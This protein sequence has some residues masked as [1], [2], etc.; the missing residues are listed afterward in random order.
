MHIRRDVRIRLSGAPKYYMNKIYSAA[1]NCY[2]HDLLDNGV[3]NNPRYYHIFVGVNTRYLETYPLNSKSNTDVQKTLTQFINKYHPEKLISDDESAFTSKSTCDL[4]TQN[5]VKIYIVQDKNHSSLGVIDRVIRTLRDMN[6][7][8]HY[9]EQS[10]D[11]QF[12]YFSIAKMNRLKNTYNNKYNSNLKCTPKEMF[13]D[14]SKELD[15][16]TSMQK[17]KNFQ[18]GIKDFKLNTG[19]YVRFRLDK[20]PL[21]KHRYN[22]TFESYKISGREGSNYILTA[23]DGTT[24]TKPRFKLLACDVNVFPWAHSLHNNRGVIEKIISYNARTNKYKVKYEN[25]NEIDEIPASFLRGRMP[26][27]MSD[28]EK[29]FF[30]N[31]AVNER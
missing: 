15:F 2:F 23:Q 8:K 30:N 28:L 4:C 20:R 1:P 18:R 24:I 27:R 25:Y 19:T 16:I 21:T 17:H 13:E 14:R 22:Y 7:P 12:N 5:D 29:E 10:T 26:Q 6:I 3:N 11:K 9:H 31:N